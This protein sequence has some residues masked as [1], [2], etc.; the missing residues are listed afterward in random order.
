VSGAKRID[1]NE[2]RALILFDTN[3]RRPSRTDGIDALYDA[4]QEMVFI[5]ED[6]MRADDLETRM[7]ELEW[8]RDLRALP[9]TWPVIRVGGRGFSKFTEDRFAKPFDPRFHE[10]MCSVA[11]RLL[12]EL[13]ALYVYT[14]SDEISVLLPRE[15]DLFDREVEQLISIAAGLASATFTQGCGEIA[16]FHA[17]LWLGP[18]AQHVAEYFRWR[19]ANAAHG[20]L[21]AWC[22]WA[23]RKD[24]FDE[25][26]STR[27]L[28]GKSASE[29]Q[30]LL[31]QR[32]INL[33]NLPEWQRRGTG[34][35]WERYEKLGLGAERR[36]IKRDEAL[37]L[38]QDYDKFIL[39]RIEQA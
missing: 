20:C 36:R 5:K 23:L 6:W 11:E 19:Q 24:G 31:F 8:F 27:Q 16:H 30:E 14:E 33:N 21:N 9:E 35:Y 34:I 12:L 38:G 28:R 29:L 25:E 7:R 22:Y 15:S 10:I 13:Q 3:P 2:R 37:P 18:S 1:R 39:A 17:R 4:G 32:G 26:A